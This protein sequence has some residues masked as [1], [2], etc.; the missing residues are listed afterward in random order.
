LNEKY[1]SD[2]ERLKNK[3]YFIGRLAEY[4]YYDMDKAVNRALEVFEK[5]FT[6]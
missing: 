5:E 2:A 3:V 1:R 6:K 4:K